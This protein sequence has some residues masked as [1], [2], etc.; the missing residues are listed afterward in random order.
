MKDLRDLMSGETSAPSSEATSCDARSSFPSCGTVG[1]LQD[2]LAHATSCDAESS[3]PSCGRI[4]GLQG[5][6]AH[7]KTQPPWDPT[8]GLCLGS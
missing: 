5:Y 1:G 3:F 7:R 6:L 4:G 2:R 8:V